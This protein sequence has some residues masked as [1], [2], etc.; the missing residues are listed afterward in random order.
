METEMD[1][2]Q[3]AITEDPAF[4]FAALD[5]RLSEQSA[6]APDADTVAL[7]WAARDGKLAQHFA[8]HEIKIGNA[9][10]LGADRTWLLELGADLGIALIGAKGN[11]RKANNGLQ[12]L[13]HRL[14]KE[15]GAGKPRH[16][17]A[18]WYI[19]WVESIK[20]ELHRCG[21]GSSTSGRYAEIFGVVIGATEYMRDR[22]IKPTARA[23]FA[24]TG[25]V[26]LAG[27]TDTRTAI[28]IYTRDIPLEAWLRP[29]T[30][31][32]G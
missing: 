27:E 3:H 24:M 7:W 15:T 5:W 11:Y 30:S 16:R 9:A 21:N 26:A 22:G 25:K 18:C 8:D 28:R 10:A 13:I 20:N 31:T 29:R 12:R 6:G 17:A 1:S 4:D 32:N 2:S 19:C 23:I 14:V